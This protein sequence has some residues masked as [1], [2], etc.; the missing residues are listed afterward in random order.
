MNRVPLTILLYLVMPV[1]FGQTAANTWSVKF[2][3][4]I[5]SRWPTTINSM[6]GKG[7][8]YSNSIILHGMEKVYNDTPNLA[9]LNYIKKYV[10]SYVDSSGNFNFTLAQTLDNIHPGILCLFL[11]EKT[12]RTKFKTA[13]TQ[14]RNFLVGPTSTYPKTSNGGYWHKGTNSAYYNVMML[15]GIYMAHP[16]LVKYGKLFNDPVCYDTATSQALLLGSFV[17]DNT[18]HLAR[19]A[20]TTDLTKAWATSPSGVSR[21]VWSRAMGWYAMALVDMLKY[22]PSTHAKYASIKA[23]LANLAIGIQNTQDPATG[24]WYQVMNKQDSAANYLETSGSAMFVYALKVAADSGWIAPSY[25]TVAQNG[26]N[27]LKAHSISTF[28]GDGKPEIDHYAPAMSVQNS[29]TQYVSGANVAVNT[30]SSVNPHGYAAILMAAS[31]MEFPLSMAS[32]PV[33]FSSFTAA[34]TENGVVLHWANPDPGGEVKYYIIQRSADGIHFTDAGQVKA[35]GQAVYHWVDNT[36]TGNTL[37]YRVGAA[38][39]DGAVYYSTVQVV[40]GRTGLPAMVVSPN[41][42]DNR[43]V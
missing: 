17:Y 29:Y 6:T 43:R 32:L 23:L 33:K 5:I 16:F 31:V 28:S 20:W 14:L 8:E 27:G 18:I 38:D 40:K 13:A 12:G 19:H 42:V 2:S 39:A 30:P 11:Y 41:P 37:Y 4:A 21:E 25:L 24:L 7:W 3:D 36:A 22:L 34:A 15:D 26:W 9:Y 1:S 10:E 35:D